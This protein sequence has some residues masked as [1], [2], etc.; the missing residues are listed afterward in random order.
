MSIAYLAVTTATI[1][2]TGG[3][4]VAAAAGAPFVLKFMSE[5]GVPESWLPKLGG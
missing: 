1:A 3:I 4:G 5:V 2:A